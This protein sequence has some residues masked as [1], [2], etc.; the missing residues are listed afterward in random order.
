M[1]ALLVCGFMA[2][3]GSSATPTTRAAAGPSTTVAEA[4]PSSISRLLARARVAISFD[5][6]DRTKPKLGFRGDS[7]TVKAT[8]ALL[9]EFSGTFNIA[10]HATTGFVVDQATRGAALDA[11]KKP[12]VEVINL[13][14]NDLTCQKAGGCGTGF[15]RV[16]QFDAAR[17][18]R[19]LD[20][21]EAKFPATTCVV[22]VTINTH[23]PSWNPVGARELNAHIRTKAH[24]L[25]WDAMWKP[26]YTAPDDPHPNAVGQ[27]AFATALRHTVEGCPKRDLVAR[28]G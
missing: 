24:V 8:P 9:K 12:Q 1:L 11:E 18:N 21:I 25:D 14:T 22:F 27:M 10:I 28:P 19:Q 2:A 6:S 23:N 3:C 4:P 16:P 26:T 5:N 20:A 13:G 7:I 17:V 15:L